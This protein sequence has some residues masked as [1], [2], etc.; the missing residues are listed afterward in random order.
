MVE[1]RRSRGI[2]HLCAQG[3]ESADVAPT[4]HTHDGGCL[5][6]LP[7]V[8]ETLGVTR[9][10]VNFMVRDGRLEGVRCGPRW[11]V[12]RDV[13]DAYRTDYQ[14]APSAGRKLGPRAGEHDMVAVVQALLEDWGEARVDELSEVIGRDPGNVR[15]YLAILKQRGAAT[16]TTSCTWAPLRSGTPA[17]HDF[18]AA[19]T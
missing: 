4:A 15:K 10:A 7:A 1:L 11:Y 12:C 6:G 14:P 2:H 3:W 13:L 9:A 8:A 17:T 5:L 16:K 19:M 18:D